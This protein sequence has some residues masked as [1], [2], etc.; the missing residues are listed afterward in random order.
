LT[1]LLSLFS[2]NI[3]PIF[4]A[5]GSGFLLAKYLPINPRTVSQMAF[6][7]FSPCLVFNLLTTSHLSTADV[8][9]MAGFALTGLV[10]IGLLTW[11]VGWLIHLERRMLVAVLLTTMFCNAGNYGL[12][13]NQFAFGDTALAHA[14]LFFVTNSVLMYT[15][16]VIVAS[17]GNTDLR[18]ALLGLLK[19]PVVYAVVL[20]FVFLETGWQLPLPINRTVSLLAN[21]SIPLLLV[22]MGIQLRFVQW[23]GQTQALT[24][25]N[26]MRLVA[27][28]V[29]AIGLSLL[30]Q[31]HGPARQAGILESAMPSA[32]S[33]TV[34][35]TEYEVEPSFVSAVVFITTVLSPITVTPLLS[36]LGA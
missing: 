9:R 34:L 3:L 18:A 13:L 8:A 31:L 29:V 30:F 33:T 4:L 7:I 6:Y 15:V 24:L 5:A 11:I 19:V 36:F 17:L 22:L 26:L 28:P 10:I 12:S 20:A 27:A 32:V 35:A 2:D 21:A 1:G 23:N 14:S 25:S 16:G